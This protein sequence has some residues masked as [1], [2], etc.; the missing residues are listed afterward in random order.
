MKKISQIREDEEI[1]TYLEKR[2]F[3]I[4]YKKAKTYLL[5]GHTHLVDFKIRK[6]KLNNIYQ[7]RINKQFRAYG[8]FDT[9]YPNIFRVIEISN[10]QD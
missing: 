4:Q 10:H 6:P 8:F 5:W 2:G 1:Y 9:N 7:F 3:I